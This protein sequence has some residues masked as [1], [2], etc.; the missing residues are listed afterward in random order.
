MIA[1]TP[2]MIAVIKELIAVSASQLTRSPAIL[3]CRRAR[4]HLAEQAERNEE[5]A[6]NCRARPHLKRRAAGFP[7]RCNGCAP[8]LNG[9][10]ELPKAISLTRAHRVTSTRTSTANF[11]TDPCFTGASQNVDSERLML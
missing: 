3:A 4:Y 10:R 11:P 6:V 5:V 8:P 1:V 2:I 7:R 9:I